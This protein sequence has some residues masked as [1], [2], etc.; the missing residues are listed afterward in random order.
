MGSTSADIHQVNPAVPLTREADGTIHVTVA[1]STE[2]A[3]L[4]IAAPPAD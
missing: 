1:G 4:S 2:E 3:S